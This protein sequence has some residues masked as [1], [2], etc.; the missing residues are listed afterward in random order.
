MQTKL[1]KGNTMKRKTTVKH[2]NT[3]APKKGETKKPNI[4]VRIEAS[5]VVYGD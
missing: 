1:S 4:P 3:A 2:Y 5:L